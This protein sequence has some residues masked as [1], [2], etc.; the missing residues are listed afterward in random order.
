MPSY[1]LTLGLKSTKE[2]YQTICQLNLNTHLPRKFIIDNSFINKRQVVLIDST[3]FICQPDGLIITDP[4]F[5]NQSR[6]LSNYF[7]TGVAIDF[8]GGLWCSTLLQGLL[9]I[10]NKNLKFY[11]LPSKKASHIHAIIPTQNNLIFCFGK[12]NNFFSIEK[13]TLTPYNHSIENDQI[14]RSFLK[15]GIKIENPIFLENLFG[16]VTAIAVYDSN[17]YLTAVDKKGLTFIQNYNSPLLDSLKKSKR[18]SENIYFDTNEEEW[19]FFDDLKVMYKMESKAPFLNIRIANFFEKIFKIHPLKNGQ[20]LLGTNNGV[21][22]LTKN[23][24]VIRNKNL[25]ELNNYRIQDILELPSGIL[26]FATKANGLFYY[27]NGTTK[28][29]PSPNSN[30]N[31]TYYQFE[32]DS[33]NNQILVSSNR[34][35]FNIDA[36]NTPF[37][38]NSLIGTFDGLGTSDIRQLHLTPDKLYFANSSGVSE[39]PRKGLYK[40]APAPKISFVN[41]LPNLSKNQILPH[42]SDNIEFLIGSISYKF[43]GQLKYQYRLLPLQPNWKITNNNSISYNS[44]RPD[45]YRLEVKAIN[46]QNSSSQTKSIT[47]EIK[48][49]FWMTNW[50]KGITILITLG[51]I[52]FI[53][54]EVVKYY[55]RQTQIQKNINELQILALQ[56]KMNPHFIFN[57]LNSIQNFILKNEKEKANDYLL[58]FAKLVRIILQNS[59]QTNITI[60]NELDTLALYVDLEVKRLRKSFSYQVEIDPIIDA[61]NALI[62]SLLIQP[63]VENSI[64]HG[65][66]YE[67]PKGIILIKVKKQEDVLHFEISDNGIG[68]KNSQNL[69]L[70][71]TNHQSLGSEITKSR[72]QLLGELNSELSKINIKPLFANNSEF[73]GTVVS[74]SIPYIIKKR[75]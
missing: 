17:H 49:A 61:N 53:T 40:K 25:M 39:T 3:V 69:K 30:N 10:S 19:Y 57:S 52:T 11:N 68:I 33:L 63:Y 64:W 14:K 47:F 2:I 74:F 73:P 37:I 24:K 35:I 18:K 12:K 41:S 27:Q 44:L 48:P 7:I 60:K 4:S 75:S 6:I 66:V 8:E 34:G 21:F 50:F 59:N 58:E 38:Q 5:K 55:K 29:I 62:P 72:I 46:I 22:E 43:G 51:I 45:K 1:E 54:N 9:Y 42:D 71:K 13:E 65:K 15:K 20:V 31:I 16:S 56:S 36:K 28:K 26:F 67:N 23:N 32:Y 70:N